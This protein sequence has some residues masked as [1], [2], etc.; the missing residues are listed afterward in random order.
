MLYIPL[1]KKDLTRPSKHRLDLVLV[2]RVH[3]L[4]SQ[5]RLLLGRLEHVAQPKP[6]IACYPEFVDPRGCN[7][8]Q[9]VQ[10]RD[11]VLCR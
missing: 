5:H 1:R 8:L 10:D 4:P 3:A 11:P 7:L 2:P 6:A 9:I